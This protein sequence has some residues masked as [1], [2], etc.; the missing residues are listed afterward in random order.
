MKTSS[1]ILILAWFTLTA[2][3]CI[4]DADS[5]S[6]EKSRS[7]DL[8]TAIL[9]QPSIT[10]DTNK[11]SA[12]IKELE[13][14]RNETS[15]DWWNNLA[16]AHLRLNQPAEAAK[17][18]EP[19]AGK[20]PNDYGLHANLGT[21][22]HLLGRYAEAEKE[23]ARD[24]EINPA[25]HFGLEKYHLALLQYLMRDAKYQSRHVYVDELTIPFLMAYK[26]RMEGFYE[27][28]I[29][30]MA[31]S[32]YTNGLAEAEKD[33]AELSQTDFSKWSLDSFQSMAEVSALEAKPA[34]RTNWNLGEITN[35]E[36]GVIYMAQMNPQEPACATMLGIAAW[37][38]RDYNL[39]AKAFEK[40]IALNSPQTAL[41]QNKIEGLKYF[42]ASSMGQH[43]PLSRKLLFASP[44]ILAVCLAVGYFFYAKFRDERRKRSTAVPSP[45]GRGLG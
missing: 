8:A 31:Q 23:I 1:C 18:L 35:L 30:G 26:G 40:A 16:G 9:G 44:F 14:S 38:K 41:L 33:L 27:E 11:L 25:A 5:L 29:S 17:L 19:V 2:R 34:Y 43:P 12:R 3:A 22:Y 45:R 39:A 4:W 28:F 7:H 21:A 42:I 13:A 36:A 32:D 15:A 20:F 24:L 6:H 10:E 37:K